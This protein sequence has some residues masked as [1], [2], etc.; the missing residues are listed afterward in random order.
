MAASCPEGTKGAVPRRFIYQGKNLMYL[1]KP[2]DPNPPVRLYVV[3]PGLD[4]YYFDAAVEFQRD[5]AVG[6]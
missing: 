4:M 6:G 3:R 5:D 2:V 1:K